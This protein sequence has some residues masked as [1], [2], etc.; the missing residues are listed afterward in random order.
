MKSSPL[1]AQLRYGLMNS[2]YFTLKITCTPIEIL[3]NKKISSRVVLFFALWLSLVYIVM[4][5]E[6]LS[7]LVCTSI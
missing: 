5:C 2:K 1:V 7:C 6:C 4:L 3:T